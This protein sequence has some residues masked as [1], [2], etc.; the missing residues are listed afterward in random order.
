M[1]ENY[2]IKRK[3]KLMAQFEKYLHIA[4]KILSKKIEDFK[5]EKLSKKMREEFESLI[6]EIQYIGGTKNSFTSLLVENVKILAFIR[7]LESEGWSYLKI[8]EFT[9]ELY[10]TIHK[11]KKKKLEEIGKNPAE[12]PFQEVYLSYL[13]N[14]SEF[15][16][17][18][19]YPDDYIMKFIEGDGETFDYGYQITQCPIHKFF[20][21]MGAE[22]Y[23]PFICLSDFAEANVNGFGFTRTQTLGYR[24]PICDHRYKK[25]GTTPRGWPPDTLEEWKMDKDGN[26]KQKMIK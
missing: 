9:Y 21:K 17:K 22:K 7:V 8:G 19:E 15:S 25:I 26:F 1:I 20:K 6:P 2:Y 10:E 18:T 24:D 3:V 4:N 5:E 16:Q 12:Q 13:K 11:I 14:L 23:A